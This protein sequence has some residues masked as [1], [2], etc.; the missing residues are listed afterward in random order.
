MSSETSETGIRPVIRGQRSE[1]SRQQLNW[2][3]RELENW[4]IREL[5]K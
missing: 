1:D 2:E 4:G 5:V 3:I